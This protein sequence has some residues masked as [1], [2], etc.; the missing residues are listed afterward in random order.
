MLTKVLEAHHNDMPMSV[1]EITAHE[2]QP[3]LQLAP[4]IADALNMLLLKMTLYN[5]TVKFYLRMLC[6]HVSTSSG[7]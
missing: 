1:L 4:N 5:F 7:S 2:L 3:F 6:V